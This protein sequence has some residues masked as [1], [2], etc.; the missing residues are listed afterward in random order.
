MGSHILHTSTHALTYTFT[1]HTR[2]RTHVRIHTHMHK[3]AFTHAQQEAPPH[4]FTTQPQ[5]RAEE[6][7]NATN[8]RKKKKKTK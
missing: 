4:L 8:E 2:L 7:F 5:G 6:Q 3:P 1:T